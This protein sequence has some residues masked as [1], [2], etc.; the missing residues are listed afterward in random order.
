MVALNAIEGWQRRNGWADSPAC[1]PIS[2]TWPPISL[3][4]RIFVFVEGFTG[5][6]QREHKRFTR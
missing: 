1:A 3:G 5:S 6:V 4:Q 2:W